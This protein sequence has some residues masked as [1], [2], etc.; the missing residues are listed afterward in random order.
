MDL[1]GV[2]DTWVLWRALVIGRCVACAQRPG[3]SGRRPGASSI[4]RFLSHPKLGACSLRDYGRHKTSKTPLETKD[5]RGPCL[6][7]RHK[8]TSLQRKQGAGFSRICR[9]GWG[10]CSGATL[11]PTPLRLCQPRYAHANPATLM[12]TPL[13]SSQSPYAYDARQHQHRHIN[14]LSLLRLLLR[15]FASACSAPALPLFHGGGDARARWRRRSEG[16]VGQGATRAGV[17]LLEPTRGGASWVRTT[18]MTECSD[19]R[20]SARSG[21]DRA[22][23]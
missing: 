14:D 12:P 19:E 16:G 9:R 13:R 3:R 20:N 5:L 22:W 10:F 8:R 6:E 18:G 23:R 11:T 15:L 1:G 2:F 7:M 4:Q 21:D 17:M